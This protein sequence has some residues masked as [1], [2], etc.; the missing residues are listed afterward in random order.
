V[1]CG[2]AFGFFKCISVDINHGIKVCNNQ[3][4]DVVECIK[5]KGAAFS[6]NTLGKCNRRNIA[7]TNLLVISINHGIGITVGTGNNTTVLLV[8]LFVDGI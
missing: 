1:S 4:D 3:F 5:V 2:A 8:T 7:V 6:V